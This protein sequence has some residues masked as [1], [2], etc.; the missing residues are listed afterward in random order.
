MLAEP[1]LNPEYL[2][3]IGWTSDVSPGIYD[4]THEEVKSKYGQVVEERN[5]KNAGLILSSRKV[6]SYPLDS[7]VPHGT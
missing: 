6:L 7:F 3:E 1:R 4:G 2:I 5:C